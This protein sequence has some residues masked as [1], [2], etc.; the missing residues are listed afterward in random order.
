MTANEAAIRRRY[1]QRLGTMTL[2]DAY[3]I[4]D[5]ELVAYV[6]DRDRFTAYALTF[7]R[8]YFS[9]VQVEFSQSQDGEALTATTNEG[10]WHFLFHLDPI[11]VDTMR[12]AERD[13]RLDHQLLVLAGM[14][15]D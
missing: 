2:V 3:Y 8:Q 13:Q 11:F 12:A 7:F 15:E 4:E 14:A 5:E 6:T 10:D 1:P 9:K